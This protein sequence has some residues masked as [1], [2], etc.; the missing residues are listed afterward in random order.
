MQDEA[1]GTT[2][3]S[4]PGQAPM[5]ALD[6]VVALAELSEHLLRVVGKQ[7]SARPIWTREAE[8]FELTRAA[9]LDGKELV[10]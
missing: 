1:R 5:D 8:R 9:D 6:D 10:R 4:L 3:P 2:L 7:P